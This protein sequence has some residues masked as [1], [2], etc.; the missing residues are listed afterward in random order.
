MIERRSR[1]HLTEL[2][3]GEPVMYDATELLYSAR[4]VEALLVDLSDAVTDLLDELHDQL[5]YEV[6]QCDGLLRLIDSTY[7]ALGVNPV[8]RYSDW[9]A[10][11][12]S[13][14]EA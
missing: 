7:D 5:A 1:L 9:G 2:G 11:A 4:D 6:G 13:E 8:M 12:G 14:A 10:I 3:G